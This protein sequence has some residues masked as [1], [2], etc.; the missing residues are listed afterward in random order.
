MLP[1][2]RLEDLPAYADPRFL[3]ADMPFMR[4]DPH[5][6][7]YFSANYMHASLSFYREFFASAPRPEF[8]AAL[9]AVHAK[10][11][12]IQAEQQHY[13]AAQACKLDFDICLHLLTMQ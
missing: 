7:A 8:S 1:L 13:S 9:W 3:Y 12:L 6:P 10:E 4:H 5:Y 11:R 2:P